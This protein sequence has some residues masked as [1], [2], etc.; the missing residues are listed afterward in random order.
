MFSLAGSATNDSMFKEE[1][2]ARIP[3]FTTFCMMRKFHNNFLQIQ[4]ELSVATYGDLGALFR[5]ENTP[6]STDTW[7]KPLASSRRNIRLED[8]F[9]LTA[10]PGMGWPFSHAAHVLYGKLN[11]VLG[12]HTGYVDEATAFRVRDEVVDILRMA[13]E[14]LD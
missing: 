3:E 8:V 10:A 7:N 12:Y 6:T 9:H 13:T 14:R 1:T 5:R 11:Y 2:K 4:S